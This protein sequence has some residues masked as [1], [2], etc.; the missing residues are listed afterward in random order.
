MAGMREI[1]KKAGTSLS[2][3]SVVLS[4]TTDKY[5]SEEI[6]ERVLKAARELKYIPCP[7]VRNYQEKSIA[8]V[9]PVI[10]SSFFSNVLSGAESCVYKEKKQLIYYNTNYDFSRE[11]ECLKLL[12]RKHIQGIILD[13]V[14]PEEQEA[15]Y[16]EW[17]K[18]TFSERGIFVVML[19]QMSSQEGLYSIYIDNFSAQKMAVSHLI[20]RGH[21]KIAYIAGN[22]KV[23]WTKRRLEGYMAALEE[24]G[25]PIDEELIRYGDYSPLSGYVAM[26]QLLVMR[27]DFTAVASANDQM[28]IGAIKAI[29][30]I[31]RAVPGDIAVTGF[32]NLSIA[33]LIDPALTT[34]HVP[35]YQ[36]GKMAVE[37]VCKL[38]EREDIIQKNQLETSLVIRKSSDMQASN[39][40]EMLGW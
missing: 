19:E 8:V 16:G 35:T 30:Q 37:I 12:K 24:A 40:W 10:T 1:A 25:I 36:M 20:S 6:R 18:K 9:L 5:V 3:V 17:L 32:D 22:Q 29:R 38:A 15:A 34:I 13:S 33:S 26:N 27:N 14:C 2:T 4:E 11:Q 31:G 28:A 23:S 21:R 39:E 7:N